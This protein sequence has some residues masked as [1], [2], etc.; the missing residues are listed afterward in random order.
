MIFRLRAI[1]G[2]IL[3]NLPSYSTLT[4]CISL[5]STCSYV[6]VKSGSLS[7][8]PVISTLQVNRCFEC[9]L[10]ISFLLHYIMP[11]SDFSWYNIS[12]C[13]HNMKNIHSVLKSPPLFVQSRQEWSL[14]WF[15]SRLFWNNS[16]GFSDSGAILLV[17]AKWL[18]FLQEICGCLANTDTMP[19]NRR[20][21]CC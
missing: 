3:N 6:R 11:L 17:G 9:I 1:N 20:K 19:F 14:M 15:G 2:S 8:Q 4:Q 5:S 21:K 7:E 10:N 12:T 16:D 18:L 13:V